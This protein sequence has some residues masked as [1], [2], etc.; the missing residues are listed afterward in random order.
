MERHQDEAGPDRLNQ[1]SFRCASLDDVHSFWQQFVARGVP[2]EM[3]VSH[4]NAIGV[5]FLDPE[6][7]TVEVYWDTGLEARQ[8]WMDHV[9]FSRSARRRAG[10]GGATGPR[11]RYDRLRRARVPA[12]GRVSGDAPVPWFRPSRSSVPGCSA[13]PSRSCSSTPRSKW[14]WSTR[15]A[16]A[17]NSVR[18]AVPMRDACEA[19]TSAGVVLC[20]VDRPES[21]WAVVAGT[22]EPRDGLA[23][24]LRPDQVY[25][26][27]T[28]MSPEA[29]RVEAAEFAARGVGFVE[30]PVSGRPPQL[31]ALVGGDTGR[32]AS[33]RTVLEAFTAY[34]F[35]VGP[36]GAGAVAKLVNQYLTYANLMVAAQGVE[37]GM[38][39]GLDPRRLV[40]A[41]STCAGASRSLGM[42]GT[43]LDD[44]DA[45]YGSVGTI[46]HD[47]D[48]FAQLVR[49]AGR[50][51]PGL[52]E[53]QALL[54]AAA[55]EDSAQPFPRAFAHFTRSTGAGE[56]S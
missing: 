10:A 42:L 43:I 23:A 18:G 36:V 7:N 26:E 6:G 30:C 49:A 19:A 1:I 11:S 39:G 34:R 22:G 16:S 45:A 29:A 27:L 20:C 12:A 25:V 48:E 37:I 47:V 32:V 55:S 15:D 3:T 53:L 21:A 5:Y 54:A 46:A 35:H 33:V 17:R 24:V 56:G 31:T 14:S 38:L 4:G 52:G 2:I 41:L 40:D 50:G 13:R 44:G 8:P 28:T 9:D 51:A